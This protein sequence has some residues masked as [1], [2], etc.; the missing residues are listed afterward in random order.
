MVVR[1][2][3]KKFEDITRTLF[4]CKSILKG[5]NTYA[6]CKTVKFIRLENFKSTCACVC[7][8]VCVGARVNM[9]W[10]WS[11]IATPP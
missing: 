5:V 7:V 3:N 9:S 2:E 6:N 8:C 11:K 1:L 4:R 10:Q